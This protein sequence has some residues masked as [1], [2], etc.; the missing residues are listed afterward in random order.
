M[1]VQQPNTIGFDFSQ[2]NTSQHEATGKGNFALQLA[3]FQSHTLNSLISSTIGQR[4]ESQP[5]D[6][7]FGGST[8][9][10]DSDGESNPL[11]AS[12]NN[13]L[14]PNGRNMSLFDPEAGYK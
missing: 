1:S 9:G 4:K 5:T 11:F 14:S 2:F 7:I 6:A 12:G 3:E 10:N 8:S 13:G